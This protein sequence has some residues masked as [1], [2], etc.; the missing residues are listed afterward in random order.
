MPWIW[1]QQES[2]FW[3]KEL[4]SGVDFKKLSEFKF[5]GDYYLWRQFS[6][7][8]DLNIVKAHIGGFRKHPGQISEDKKQYQNEMAGI[9]ECR[10]SIY[11]YMAG[12]IDTIVWYMPDRIKCALNRK[13]IKL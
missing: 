13:I 4:L 5:A 1:I 10:P 11:D 3:R 6:K 12:F 8:S 7:V 9:L 2:T